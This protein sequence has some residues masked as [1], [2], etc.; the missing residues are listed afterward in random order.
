MTFRLPRSG[1]LVTNQVTTALTSPSNAL[2]R[3]VV[4][5]DLSLTVSA[6]LRRA[7]EHVLGFKGET[8]W[9]ELGVVDEHVHLIRAVLLIEPRAGQK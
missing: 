3:Q 2:P 1:N 9:G 6:A 5:L 4:L 7:V 8:A